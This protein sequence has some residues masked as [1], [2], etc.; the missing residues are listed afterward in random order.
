MAWTWSD[1]VVAGR[2]FADRVLDDYGTVRLDLDF[3]KVPADQRKAWLSG[4]GYALRLAGDT[5]G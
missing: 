5:G 3:A 2:D 4:F 1:G